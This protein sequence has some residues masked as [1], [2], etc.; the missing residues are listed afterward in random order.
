MDNKFKKSKYAA[1]VLASTMALSTVA[2]VTPQAFGETPITAHATDATTGAAVKELIKK[3]DV[4]SSTY[5]TAQTG[6][7]AKAA[8]AYEALTAA[9]KKKVSN[10]KLLQQ[11]QLVANNSTLLLAIAALPATNNATL[12]SKTLTYTPTSENDLTPKKVET[13]EKDGVTVATDKKGNIIYR[14]I[15]DDLETIANSVDGFKTA[16]D[17]A[18]A[19]NKDVKAPLTAVY[20]KY[21][22]LKKLVTTQQNNV[23]AKYKA[24]NFN[25]VYKALTT[26]SKFDVVISTVKGKKGKYKLDGD[27][28][29]ITVNGDGFVVE[30]PTGDQQ[31]VPSGETFKVVNNDDTDV[32]TGDGA[33][34]EG[35]STFYDT[36]KITTN[37]S[38]EGFIVEKVQE[39]IQLNAETKVLS[40]DSSMAAS[41]YKALKAGTTKYSD[42]Q[43]ELINALSAEY[44]KLSGAAKKTVTADQVTKMKA[45]EKAAKTQAA[46][47]KKLVSEDVKGVTKAISAIKYNEDLTVYKKA[48]DD[49]NAAYN[50]L[51]SK[52]KKKVKAASVNTLKAHKAA[53]KTVE[54][55]EKLPVTNLLKA[56][57][58]TN[59]TNITALE[60]AIAKVNSQDTSK[61]A[62]TDE[63][64]YAYEKLNKQAKGLVK[65]YKKIKTIEKLIA[66]QKDYL[67]NKTDVVAFESALSAVSSKETVRTIDNQVLLGTDVY[68]ITTDKK[69]KTVKL[70]HT[71]ASDDATVVEIKEGKDATIATSYKVTNTKGKVSIVKTLTKNATKG[72]DVLN[73]KG[74]DLATF[75]KETTVKYTADQKAAI[76]AATDAYTTASKNKSAKKYINAADITTLKKYQTALKQQQALEAKEEI[77]EYA[78]FTKQVGALKYSSKLSSEAISGNDAR[79][80]SQYQVDVEAALAKYNELAVGTPASG[81]TAA[82][83]AKYANAETKL[84]TTKAK[85]DNHVA[86]KSVATELANLPLLEKVD[87]AT[88]VSSIRLAYNGLET[89]PKAL[90]AEGEKSLTAVENKAKELKAISDAKTFVNGKT[91]NIPST[92][93]TDKKTLLEAIQKLDT[94]TEVANKNTILANL[95]ESALDTTTTGQVKVSL[96]STEKVTV[97]VVANYEQEVL[98]LFNNA[99]V[100]VT[101]NTADAIKE[102]IKELTVYKSA[103][104]GVKAFVDAATITPV[105]LPNSAT[106]GTTTATLKVN[107]D[108]NATINVTVNA[109]PAGTNE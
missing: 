45:Y 51:T 43:L 3:L 74:V 76:K 97:T 100:E 92:K 65:N 103:S 27:T 36:Y 71:P 41:A 108:T 89:A 82:V 55:I 87:A 30:D 72:A 105:A 88:D 73:F 17:A 25:E 23:D 52:F 14:G 68:K 40:L 63:G 66:T 46:L 12:T 80:K 106:T 84:A 86:A 107:A 49:A 38:V 90:L 96:S 59:D 29:T 28:Y 44:K 53:Y 95:K 70:T 19:D 69:S 34:T 13:K 20:K 109:A 58:A 67:T 56:T 79:K 39:T 93:L 33:A 83:P 50:K 35:N 15:N 31:T 61:Q 18:V 91:I 102:A 21:T 26:G 81:S 78:D 5:A 54:A 57:T 47:E 104:S 37:D 16:Y 98:S 77:K 1:I 11:H 6:D 60:E 7:V 99:S 32:V 42:K 75:Q 85:L 94:A 4:T 101:A 62:T 8:A 10:Y 22:T 2:S 9:E 64:D 48:I 24:F